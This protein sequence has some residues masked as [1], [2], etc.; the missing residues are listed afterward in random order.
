MVGHTH[1]NHDDTCHDNR[2]AKQF[3][4]R[5]S[6]VKIVKPDDG[7]TDEAERFPRGIR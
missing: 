1:V 2:H 7:D 5:Q 3:V 6:L 4:W